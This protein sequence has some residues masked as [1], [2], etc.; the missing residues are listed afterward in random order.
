[1]NS[2]EL[3]PSEPVGKDST[4]QRQRLTRQEK[5]Q[6]KLEYKASQFAL[7]KQQ[8]REKR[9]LRK[10]EQ[11]KEFDLRLAKCKYVT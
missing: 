4:P 9:V 2:G 6:K 5:K 10:E 1:M 8:A 7:K 11:Q 3:T